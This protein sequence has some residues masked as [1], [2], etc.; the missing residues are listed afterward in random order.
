MCL[1]WCRG[2]HNHFSPSLLN[3]RMTL[4]GEA[5]GIWSSGRNF[6]EYCQYSTLGCHVHRCYL[7]EF[8][9]F[10]FPVSRVFRL[11]FTKCVPNFFFKIYLTHCASQLY[12]D[13]TGTPW[14]NIWLIWAIPVDLASEKY[15]SPQASQARKERRLRKGRRETKRYFKSKL[16]SQNPGKLSKVHFMPSYT[17]YLAPYMGTKLKEMAAWNGVCM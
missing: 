8:L 13:K 4:H 7:M 3:R 14:G 9:Y 12:S 17:T 10:R 5:V 15:R 16:L 1:L 6:K 11:H 2:R